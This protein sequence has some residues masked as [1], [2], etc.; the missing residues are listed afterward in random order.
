MTPRMRR[1]STPMAGAS[2]FRVRMAG[3]VRALL[4]LHKRQGLHGVSLGARASR[5]LEQLWAFGPLRA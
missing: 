2:R 5:P 1:P 3:F 4:P